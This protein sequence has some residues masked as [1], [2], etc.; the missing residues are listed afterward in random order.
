METTNLWKKNLRTV[1]DDV[2]QQSDVR[3]LILA[4]NGLTQLPSQIGN[5]QN[6]RTLDLGHNKLL[7]LPDEIGHIEELSDFL[8]LHDNQLDSLPSSLRTTPKTPLP[9]HQRK[10]F[11]SFPAC[12]CAMSSLSSSC[13]QR[14]IRSQISRINVGSLSK[15]REL[16]LRNNALRTLPPAIG[17]LTDLRQIDLRGNPIETLP[18]ALLALPKLQQLSTCVGSMN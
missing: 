12:L 1:P 10:P 7:Q 3:V 16:H 15:L 11:L 4:D 13:A 14:T 5:L 17:N 8:Y 18:D 9:E 6:L 2:W